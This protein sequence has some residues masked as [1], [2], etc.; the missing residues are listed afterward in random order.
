MSV[1]E[2]ESRGTRFAGMLL[3]G[4]AV[5]L[6]TM[7]LV[8][9]SLHFVS[10]G[11]AKAIFDQHFAAHRAL[12]HG[13]GYLTEQNHERIIR[14]LPIAAGIFGLRPRADTSQTKIGLFSG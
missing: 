12:R 4:L 9:L 8:L 14:N 5:L 7:A 10:Y 3:S 2:G 13:H 6:L 1:A 11:H